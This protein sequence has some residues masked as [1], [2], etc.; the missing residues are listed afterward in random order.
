MAVR[1]VRTIDPKYHELLDEETRPVPESFRRDSPIQPGPTHV[2]VTNY[3]TQE[4]HDLEV[5]KVWKRVW[6][7]AAHEDDLPD[8]GDYLPYD[9][10]GLSFLI[11]K[12]DEDEYKA[13]YN[14][15]LH[16]GRKLREHRGKQ[17]DELRCPFHAWCWNIDG[18]LKQIPCEWDYPDL[19]REEQSLP[20][21]NLARWGRYIFI[22][23]DPDCEPFEDFIGDL[24]SHFELLPYEKRYKE[25]HVA[26]IIRCNWKIASEAFMESYHVI[27]THPQILMGGAHDVDTKYDV[28]GNYSRAIRCGALESSGLPQWEP[29]PDDGKNRLQHP[30]NGFVYERISDDSSDVRVTAPDGRTGVFDIQARHKEGD[31]TEVN[32]HLVNWVGGPQLPQMDFDKLIREKIKNA[33]TGEPLNPRTAMAD[34]QRDAMRAVVP[35]IAEDIA[36]I[37][38]ASIFFTLFPNFHP[39]GSFNKINYRFRPNGNNPEECIMECIYLAPIPENGEYEPC[40]EIHWLG[41]DDDWTDA[42]ELGML[43]KVFNQDCRNLPLVQEGLHATAME[44]LQFADYNETKPRHFEMLLEEWINRD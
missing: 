42:P 25:A 29:L 8:V 22:N 32:P 5:E 12:T 11:V 9:I 24:S 41:A 21:V 38:F 2:P 16:R 1:S 44:Y 14:A 3:Y 10:A 43:C 27:A 19:K 26:K 17:A 18:S 34:F 30:L 31:L 6:Q 20:E 4:F 35:S 39:W 36:D 13:Y 7:M 37:E 40:R 15:C 23:P 28:F 33:P